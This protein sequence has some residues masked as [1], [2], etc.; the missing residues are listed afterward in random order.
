MS[1]K[2]T[3]TT[4]NTGETVTENPLVTINGTS[5]SSL[6]SSPL[7]GWLF[8]GSDLLSAKLDQAAGMVSQKIDDTHET[9]MA[10]QAK[11]M[12]VESE[13][14]RTLNPFSL[15]D[16]AQKLVTANPIFSVL[17]GGQKRQ[18][19]E[20]QLALL[21][22]KV[23]LLVEQVALLAAKEAAAKVEKSTKKEEAPK[24]S[25]TKRAPAK[26]KTTTTR[27]RA[28]AAKAATPKSSTKTAAP[29]ATTGTS[30]AKRKAPAAKAAPST[31]ATTKTSKSADTKTVSKDG[32]DN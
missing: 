6:K 15:V 9:I 2:N 11:G 1:N 20:Q 3:P 26:A 22:A 25:S 30:T 10:M 21:N 5:S 8:A 16:T 18:Q 28:T 23:D 19:K 14:K 12:E 31:T 13:L 27:T 24:A 32:E 17:S 4:T 29:K 7:F